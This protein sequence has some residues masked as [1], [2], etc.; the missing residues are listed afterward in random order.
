MLAL[1]ALSMAAVAWA[2]TRVRLDDA[3]DQLRAQGV[4][5]VYSTALAPADLYVEVDAMTLDA[6]RNAL[7]TVGLKLEARDGGWLLVKGP[8]VA[9]QGQ[10]IDA[11][12]DKQ[13]GDASRIETIIVTGTRHRFATIGAEPANV[14]SGEELDRVPALG[15]DSLRSANLLPGMSSMG[16]SVRPRIRGGLEDELLVLLDGVEILDPYHFAN[17]QN[18]FSAIDGR[19]ID[20]VDVYSGGFPARYGNRMSGVMEID[21][22]EQRDKPIA[23]VGLSMYSVFANARNPDPHSDTTWLASARYGASDQLIQRLGLQS[24]RPYFSDALFRVGHAFDPDAKLYF[25][26]LVVSEDISL[27]DDQQRATWKADSTYLWSRFDGRIDDRITSSTVVSYVSSRNQM[28]DTSSPVP[29]AAAGILNDSRDTARVAL[30]SDF[31]VATGQARQEFGVQADWTRTNYD[32]HALIDRGPLGV[33]F[34]GQAVSA[35]DIGTTLDGVSGGFYWSGDFP[36]GANLS[37]QPGV[38]WDFQTA[39]GYAGQVS[40]RFGIKW[41]PV[42]DL[43]LRF[44]AGRYYQPDGVSEM[45]TADGIDHLYKPQRADHYIASALWHWSA[46]A[47]LRI[48]AY[49]KQYERTT[50]RFEN[51]FDPF[52]LLPQVATDRVEIASA[53]ARAHGVDLEFQ[54]TMTERTSAIARYSYMDADD[55]VGGRWVPR[56]WSQRETVTGIVMWKSDALSAS[57]ALTWHSGW[58]T[59]AP[60]ASVPIGAT[61]PIE[62]VLNNRHLNDYFSVDLGFSASHPVWRS[63]VTVF[64]NVTN[65]L[66]RQ[67][68]VGIDYAVDETGGTV[69]FSP[70]HTSLL[71]IVPWVGIVIA[72]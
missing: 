26:G 19:T 35:H 37:L 60:P 53:R 29:A 62:D 23:E 4:S 2:G 12:G 51:V 65:S 1:F 8:R 41:L 57:A 18:L 46:G 50:P 71:P 49:E 38:R 44:D 32:S 6:V 3:L 72:F 27:N 66:D 34:D 7:P 24:G 33:L 16:V 39:Q 63:T 21:T 55:E 11:A 69:Q 28:R 58:R 20:D 47:Q 17:Y 45:D 67:N 52:V 36:V 61:I 9:A 42:D 43:T 70:D 25:G 5:I 15:G 64:A 59:T 31:A 48:D 30:R 14:L 13:S 22:L 68:P 56:R 40:P 10:P 54:Q